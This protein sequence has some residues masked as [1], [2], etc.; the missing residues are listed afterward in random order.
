MPSEGPAE[1]VFTCTYKTYHIFKMQSSMAFQLVS[2]E[3]YGLQ[4]SYEWLLAKIESVPMELQQFKNCP[5]LPR[6]PCI[7]YLIKVANIFPSFE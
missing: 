4:L 5:D 3:A 6:H 2:N 7:S 1:K